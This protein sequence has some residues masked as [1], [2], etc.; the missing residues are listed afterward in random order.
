MPWQ[1]FKAWQQ[2]AGCTCREPAVR[3]CRICWWR[4]WRYP[5]R[6]R[7]AQQTFRDV[8]LVLNPELRC[9]AKH[10][11]RWQPTCWWPC[12]RTPACERPGSHTLL[13]NDVKWPKTPTRN[14][15][16]SCSTPVGG[17]AGALLPADGMDYVPCW[18]QLWTLG[19]SPGL[20]HT[21]WWRCWRSPACWRPSARI[22]SSM[23]SAPPSSDD[24]AEILTEWPATCSRWGLP[25]CWLLQRLV[26]QRQ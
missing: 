5:V 10:H 26:L 20:Q 17:G 22:S 14:Q 3:Q 11:A 15:A 8:P 21:C 24:R 19:S 18:A 23:A 16:Q 13:V 7:R 6:S 12:W 9:A 1:S 25:V 4:C 2:G